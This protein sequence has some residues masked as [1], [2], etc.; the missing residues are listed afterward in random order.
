MNGYGRRSLIQSLQTLRNSEVIHPDIG[1]SRFPMVPT[2][3]ASQHD[4][5]L[6]CNWLNKEVFMSDH[7]FPDVPES[8]W[9]SF[10]RKW[11]P[12]LVALSGVAGLVLMLLE[13][14]KMMSS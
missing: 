2:L 4:A 9:S 7:F 12:T 10:L 3:W 5:R 8:K 14:W 13:I 6:S 1:V 11:T